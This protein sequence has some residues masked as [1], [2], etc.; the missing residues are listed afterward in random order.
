MRN[1]NIEPLAGEATVDSVINGIVDV[2]KIIFIVFIISAK[3]ISP[4]PM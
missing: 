2:E 3:V 1:S 4:C